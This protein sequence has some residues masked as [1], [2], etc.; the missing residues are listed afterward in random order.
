MMRGRGGTRWAM[1]VVFVVE[2]IVAFIAEAFFALGSDAPYFTLL[3]GAY[4]GLSGLA[5]I[6]SILP[7]SGG[8][9]REQRQ[10]RRRVVGR[11]V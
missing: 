6:V 9:F 7:R 3:I 2:A 11:S 1:L 5:L 4:L 10:S 8:W